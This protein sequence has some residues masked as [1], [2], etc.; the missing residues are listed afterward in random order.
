MSTTVGTER[1]LPR[2]IVLI[3]ATAFA[4]AGCAAMHRQEARSTGDILVAAGFTQKPADTADRAEKLR[5]M[6]PLKMISQ[7]KDGRISP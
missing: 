1:L 7:P 4:L 5:K 2:R 3:C 6:P